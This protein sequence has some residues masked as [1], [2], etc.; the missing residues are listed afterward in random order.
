MLGLR[1]GRQ[2]RIL[3][4]YRG[5]DTVETANRVIDAIEAEEPDA[6]V[7][8][9]DG[10]GAGVVDQVRNRGFGSRLHEFHGGGKPDDAFKY[11]NKRAEVWGLMRDWLMA[12]AEIPD[13]AELAIDLCGPQYG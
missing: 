8:D 3:G 9:G 12:T 1:Q 7:I 4:K 6:T 13:D 2:F 5:L 11:F 10:L